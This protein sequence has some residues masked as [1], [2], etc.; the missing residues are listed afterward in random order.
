MTLSKPYVWRLEDTGDEADNREAAGQR[1]RRPESD[2][3][4]AA[5]PSVF[6]RPGADAAQNM[7]PKPCS[8]PNPNQELFV[9]NPYQPFHVIDFWLE[10]KKCEVAKE[11]NVNKF[12]S[13]TCIQM[14]EL[15][16]TCDIFPQAPDTVVHPWTDER[17]NKFLLRNNSKD[18][19]SL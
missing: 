16:E 4:V 8:F 1:G 6:R 10:F 15:V 19:T 5:K 13:L 12:T 3:L 2:V 17:T 14:T 7:Y 11:G 18:Q 9:H